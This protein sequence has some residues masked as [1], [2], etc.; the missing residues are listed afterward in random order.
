[1]KHER[2]EWLAVCCQPKFADEGTVVNDE[3]VRSIDTT[4][5]ADEP[6]TYVVT[7]PTNDIGLLVNPMSSNI[8]SVPEDSDDDEEDQVLDSSSE[9]EFEIDNNE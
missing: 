3:I 8:I 4:F 9:S 2:Q 6:T 7:D 1:M 5:Q